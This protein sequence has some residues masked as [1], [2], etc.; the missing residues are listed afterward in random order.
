VLERLGRAGKRAARRTI[1]SARPGRRPASLPRSEC[2]GAAG[3]ARQFQLDA[4]R[5]RPS[6]RRSA[7]ERPGRDCRIRL[8]TDRVALDPPASADILRPAARASSLVGNIPPVRPMSRFGVCGRNV[9]LRA[10]EGIAQAAKRDPVQRRPSAGA[11]AMQ[12]KDASPCRIC[13]PGPANTGPRSS[14]PS[15]AA[16]GPRSLTCA[17]SWAHSYRIRE[18][19]REGV[20][21][22]TEGR[23]SAIRAVER[24]LDTPGGRGLRSSFRHAARQRRGGVRR[25]GPGHD[26]AGGVGYARL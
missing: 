2:R 13:G 17:H 6:V 23:A 14:N 19:S 4:E 26:P 11:R 15:S 5:A 3:V 7:C 21:T 24:G 16:C 18:L 25:D 9:L 12:G 1:G 10:S 22:W 8:L 20:H